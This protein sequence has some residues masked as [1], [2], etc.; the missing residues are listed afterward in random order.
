[1]RTKLVNVGRH[2]I[3]WVRFVDVFVVV[4]I[5]IIIIILFLLL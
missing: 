1:M 5:I 4:I 3:I 2:T